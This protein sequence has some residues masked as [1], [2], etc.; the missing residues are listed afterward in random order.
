MTSPGASQTSEG[1]RTTRRTGR[2]QEWE[3]HL[4]TLLNGYQ[5]KTCA[6]CLSVRTDGEAASQSLPP[7]TRPTKRMRLS[8]PAAPTL[9]QLDPPAPS[10]L[11]KRPRLSAAFEETLDAVKE[12]QVT[13]PK[14][15]TKIGRQKMLRSEEL[16]ED[17]AKKP[18]KAS[19]TLTSRRIVD[20]QEASRSGVE[21]PRPSKATKKA[22]LQRSRVAVRTKESAIAPVSGAEL[23]STSNHTNDPV[24]EAAQNTT[25]AS[26]DKPL[27]CFFYQAISRRTLYPRLRR[28][29]AAAPQATE[30]PTKSSHAPESSSTGSPRTAA[31][32][33]GRWVPKPT[34]FPQASAVPSLVSGTEHASLTERSH[35]THE[36]APP[37]HPVEVSTLNEDS[38]CVKQLTDSAASPIAVKCEGQRKPPVFP[39]DEVE[40]P[41]FQLL[42]FTSLVPP[43]VEAPQ[44]GTLPPPESPPCFNMFPQAPITPD[45]P[46][47]FSL[48]PPQAA[49]NPTPLSTLDADLPPTVSTP[50]SPWRQPQVAGPA[51]PP[52]FSV[53]AGPVAGRDLEANGP[54]SPILLA[55]PEEPP[56]AVIEGIDSPTPPHQPGTTTPRRA[57]R[58]FFQDDYDDIES[59]AVVVAPAKRLSSPISKMRQVGLLDDSDEGDEDVVVVPRR[60]RK[61]ADSSPLPRLRSPLRSTYSPLSSTPS[62]LRCSRRRPSPPSSPARGWTCRQC[63]FENRNPSGLACE[64]CREP[65]EP[66]DEETPATSVPWTCNVCTNVNNSDPRRCELCDT[67][68]DNDCSSQI[69]LRDDEDDED[70][71]QFGGVDSN[72]EAEVVDLTKPRPAYYDSDSIE[73]ISDNERTF[74]MQP[75]ARDVPPALREFTHFTPVSCLQAKTTAKDPGIDYVNMFGATR[76]GKSYADRRKKRLRESKRRLEN[77]QQNPGAAFQKASAKRGK[78]GRSGKGKKAPPV[79]AFRSARSAMPGKRKAAATASADAWLGRASGGPVVLSNT[80]FQPKAKTRSMRV[81]DGGMDF[82]NVGVAAARGVAPVE[83]RRSDLATWEGKGSLHFG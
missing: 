30:V 65:K 20:E 60:L 73:E 2:T 31:D 45:G 48:L 80:T 13:S 12:P 70:M 77:E 3:C 23:K 49:L 17:E 69:R 64:M 71:F 82:A 76:N 79:A 21:P 59:P 7:A 36:S 74:L 24:Q 61:P 6:A 35:D 4:C 68:R 10:P 27:G 1:A 37:P 78:S 19:A 58:S 55:S 9:S 54:H 40:P 46:P 62:P 53:P 11:A 32:L 47:A 66:Y 39:A 50:N 41:S 42:N 38:T 44:T 29:N 16:E 75:S 56:H 51:S 52:P 8:M 18:H 26:H 15:K 83:F 34:A 43:P 63:T 33:M 67:A 14:T 22:G 57:R 25:E 28:A 81:V 72:D 5:R